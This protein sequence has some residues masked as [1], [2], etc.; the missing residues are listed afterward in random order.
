M[1]LSVR[2]GRVLGCLVE[3][4]LTTPQQYP[5]T[6]NAL[7]SACSQAT[8]RH[9]VMEMDEA[10]VLA[11]VDGLKAAH[12]AR[13]VLPV[14][15]RT[16]ERFRHV[17]DEQL[18]MTTQEVALLAVLL[19]RG[20]QTA[21]ELRGRTGRMVEFAGVEQ[22][23]DILAGLSRR[24]EPLVALLPRRPG[25]KEDRWIQCLADDPEANPSDRWLETEASEDVS[26]PEAVSNLEAQVADLREE[27]ERLRGDF[28]DL[29]R[30]LGA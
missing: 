20:A 27:V 11:G 7:A 24:E 19:L 15:G 13:V 16:V 9:P 3:K 18:G 22:V 8:N 23:A 17:L 26:A 5:L 6:A 10:D 4:Q 12:L 25:Q 29:R 28:E 21:G 2:E 30:Q 14:S 1:T